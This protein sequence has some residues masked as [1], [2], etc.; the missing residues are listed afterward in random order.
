MC[1]PPAHSSALQVQRCSLDRSHVCFNTS[2]AG[3]LPLALSPLSHP[4]VALSP[5]TLANASMPTYIREG[6]LQ[7]WSMAP[8]L[9]VGS[10]QFV[11][12][13]RVT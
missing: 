3:P 6:G 7:A 1:G 9:G 8:F 12:R 4:S 11:V 10:H 13:P 5:S 2:L